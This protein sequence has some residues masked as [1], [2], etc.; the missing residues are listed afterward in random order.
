MKGTINVFK[1]IGITSHQVV[2]IVRKKFKIK[3]VGHGGT[4]DPNVSGVL[5]LCIGKGTKISQYMLDLDKEYIGEL[6]LGIETDTQDKDG[7]ILNYSDKV[8]NSTEIKE[9][10]Q[11]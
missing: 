4:L 11:K 8:V 3:K 10:F 1:P 6:T 2:N 5:I 7:K 9:T